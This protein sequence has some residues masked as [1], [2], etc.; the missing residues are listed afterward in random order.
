MIQALKIELDQHNI[1]KS[2]HVLIWTHSHMLAISFFTHVRTSLII[3]TI[4]VSC[5]LSL[6]IPLYALAKGQPFCV[7]II[8]SCFNNSIVATIISMKH[9]HGDC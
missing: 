6:I 3:V 9:Y 5:K 1:V 7:F 8:M 4:H 2:L